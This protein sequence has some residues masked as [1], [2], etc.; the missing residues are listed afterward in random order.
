LHY[1]VYRL[2]AAGAIVS[3]DWIDAE[4]ESQARA[5]AQAFCN[6]GTPSVE[7]WL[8]ARRLA[9]LPCREDASG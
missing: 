3:G 7:L 6:E 8:D 4:D 1:R 2:N 5:R 9:T